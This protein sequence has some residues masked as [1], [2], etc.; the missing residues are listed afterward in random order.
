MSHAVV[1]CLIWVRV[2]SVAGMTYNLQEIS[3]FASPGWACGQTRISG[4]PRRGF[5][6]VC[7]PPR[8][9]LGAIAG[10]PPVYYVGQSRRDKPPAQ[11]AK[12]QILDGS[13]APAGHPATPILWTLAADWGMILLLLRSV[14]RLRGLSNADFLR[15]DLRPFIFRRLSDYV[16]ARL[17]F[18][19]EVGMVRSNA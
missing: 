13:F 7:L 8:C 3:V 19:F 6:H 12:R 5:P 17:P 9:L 16:L 1:G 18:Y 2:A 14:Q 15:P 10:L 11:P 4:V